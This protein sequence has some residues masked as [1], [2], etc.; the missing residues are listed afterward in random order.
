MDVIQEEHIRKRFGIDKGTADQIA[1]W[2]KRGLKGRLETKEPSL[3][4][5]FIKMTGSE[6]L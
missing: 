5:I 1:H 6:L 3:G 2:M 4:D